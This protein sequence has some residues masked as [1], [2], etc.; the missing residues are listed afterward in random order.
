MSPADKLTSL[1]PT[2]QMNNN[3]KALISIVIVTSGSKDYLWHCIDSIKA[4][5]YPETEVIVIDNSLNP[6]FPSKI[7]E[8]FPFIK[9]YSNQ[10]NLYY[11]V[12]L[13]KGIDIGH[14]EFTLCLNDDVVL[15]PDFIHQALKGFSAMDNVGMVSGKILRMDGLTLD[16]TGLFLSI[17][18]SAKERGY[19]QRDRGKFEKP[20]FIFGV[21]GAAAFYR[22]K[23][24]EDIKRGRDYFDPAFRMFYED[25]DLS[26]RSNNRGWKAYYIP[27]AKVFHVR[28]GSFRPDNGLGKPVAR[29]YL[30]DELHSDLIK[31]RYLTILKNA[32]FFG[33]FMHLAAIML[34]DFCAWSYVLFFRPKVVKLFLDSLRGSFKVR[35]SGGLRQ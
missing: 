13:N 9:L 21:S 31:N 5:S 35:F 27:E 6:N 30:N 17:W 29:K 34:Y 14:G 24:L 22:K 10:Q 32:T 16:S 28:G 11:G 1:T 8:D 33:I 26:W 19:G 7:R 2:G 4:Q 23:M 3:L 20:G 18:Y 12:S 25:L 15:D